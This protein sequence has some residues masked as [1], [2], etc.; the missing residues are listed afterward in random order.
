MS[1]PTTPI[2]STALLYGLHPM[3]FPSIA[4][5]VV[6]EASM[7]EAWRSISGILTSLRHMG[8]RQH[9]GSYPC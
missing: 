3:R 2:E 8:K 9:L 4:L 6:L 1:L 7:R 5:M